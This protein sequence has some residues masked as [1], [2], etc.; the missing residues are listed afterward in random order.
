MPT[1]PQQQRLSMNTA[2]YEICQKPEMTSSCEITTQPS[3]DVSPAGKRLSLIELGK[4]EIEMERRRRQYSLCSLL[5]KY[6]LLLAYPDNP[7]RLSTPGQTPLPLPE[8]IP[9]K[10]KADSQTQFQGPKLQI[11]TL[12]AQYP[13]ENKRQKSRLCEAPGLP[14]TLG[15]WSWDLLPPARSYRVV[16]KLII[17]WGRG[18]RGQRQ[19]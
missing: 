8:N 12:E 10:V 18:G 17:W 13:R 19:I 5:A 4:M 7:P 14:N 3:R 11:S 6:L 1:L 16:K 15:E 2:C 9:W